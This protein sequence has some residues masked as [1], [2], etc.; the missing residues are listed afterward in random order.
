MSDPGEGQG[1]CSCIPT[2][3]HGRLC[4]WHRG[5]ERRIA[6]Q[7]D[8]KT[9]VLNDLSWLTV[10]YDI[11]C[12]LDISFE[13]LSG[14]KMCAGNIYFFYKLDISYWT[15]LW[16]DPFYSFIGFHY[17]LST[18]D[19]ESWINETKT[20]QSV[21]TISLLSLSAWQHCSSPGSTFDIRPVCLS[22][23]SS[24]QRYCVS[25]HLWHLS[26]L[27]HT[28]IACL[29]RQEAETDGAGQCGICA[30]GCV[31][32]E[33][34]QIHLCLSEDERAICTPVPIALYSSGNVGEY[35]NVDTLSKYQ[36]VKGLVEIY[37]QHFNVHVKI[38]WFTQLSVIK[39]G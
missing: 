31:F 28:H 34:L 23:A 24:Q 20:A 1:K 12:Q 21:R 17:L 32:L 14:L 19:A 30:N 7:E 35:S 36:N 13:V 8:D 6:M 22:R 11:R 18:G 4:L 2:G 29:L 5:S 15:E 37:V 26:T 25:C 38:K 27:L 39:V 16:N 10:Q 33:P 9:A 3:C